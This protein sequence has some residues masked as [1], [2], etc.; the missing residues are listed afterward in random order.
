M[1]KIEE[2]KQFKFDYYLRQCDGCGDLFKTN[3][4]RSKYCSLCKKDKN[5]ERICK[6]LMVR[7][8]VKTAEEAISKYNLD[9]LN[10]PKEEN[11]D[12]TKL[13]SRTN[14]SD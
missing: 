13:D 6:I 2:K 11:N 3:Q 4:K 10:K 8:I 9:K 14:I 12:N 5:K 1:I 7:G